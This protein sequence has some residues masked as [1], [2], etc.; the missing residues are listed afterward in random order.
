M[1][2]C[3]VA[4]LLAGAIACSTS[5]GAADAAGADVP[6]DAADVPVVALPFDWCG[7]APPDE[8]C[9]RARRDPQSDGIRLALDIARAQ[10]ARVPGAQASWG[11]EDGVLMTGM[12]ELYRVTGD[13]AL[14]DYFRTW[15]DRHIASGYF[16]TNSDTCPPAY[17]AYAL[18]RAT[19]EAK[20]RAVVDD[21]LTYLYE[22]A[23]RTA[24]GGINHLGT[25]EV[26][27]ITLWVDSLF[28]FG[29]TLIRLGEQDGDDRAIDEF[30]GQYRI[31]AEHLQEAPGLFKHAWQWAMQQDDDVYWGRGNGWV[32][33]A[34]YDYLRARAL[35]SESDEAVRESLARHTAAVVASQ[36]PQTGLWWTVLNRP[37]ETYL[38][39]SAAALFAFGLAR[40]WRT[41]VLGDDVLP[42]V[43]K[44]MEGVRSRIVDGPDGKPV[45]TGVSGPTTAGTFAQY[46]AVKVEDDLAYGIGAVILALIET[47]GLPSPGD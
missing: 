3:L 5:G 15:I 47:S 29:E 23:V 25:T 16:V 6:A 38:E 2:R 10:M 36:D 9:Y 32:S 7:D 30:A 20:Y 40:G 44:A 14:L 35:R 43:R 33:A 45:V 22:E 12:V 39:T 46:A 27:G 13:P 18:W 4:L 11:W 42:V 17:A 31:F 1:T 37:G 34:G 8:A 21:I 26:F 24:D 28:M 19:G 41:G